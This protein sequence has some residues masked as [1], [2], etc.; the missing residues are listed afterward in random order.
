MRADR[1]APRIRSALFIPG[2]RVDF[3]QK[4][5][6]RGAD[7]VILD[8]EDSVASP[9]KPSARTHAGR[10]VRDRA[11]GRSPLVTARGM[12]GERFSELEAQIVDIW[13]RRNEGTGGR[14]RLPQEY[15]LSIVRL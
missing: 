9:G 5:D 8:L 13:Q 10:W 14:F 1:P 3:L 15:L 12:L 2:Q 7:A 6:S 4:A 11:P